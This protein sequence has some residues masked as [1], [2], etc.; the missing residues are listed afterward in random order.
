VA[1]HFS[2]ST[3]LRVPGRGEFDVVLT[4]RQSVGNSYSTYLITAM[5]VSYSLD[6]YLSF[7]LYGIKI[8]QEFA[9]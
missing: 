2:T 1:D 8:G 6:I 3:Q 5:N 7:K 9:E 4:F